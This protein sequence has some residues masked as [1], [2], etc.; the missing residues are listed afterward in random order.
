MINTPLYICSLF[1]FCMI[2]ISF[3]I[4]NLNLIAA[5]KTRYVLE[6]IFTYAIDDVIFEP[7][8]APINRST[9]PCSSKSIVGHIED[10]GIFLGV[11]KFAGDGGKPYAFER[12]GTEKSSIPSFRI[13]PVCLERIL[14]PNLII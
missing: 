4:N 12:P 10:S 3:L 5:L 13:I 11:I 1:K 6:K 7:P 2:K 8:A 9:L 14:L